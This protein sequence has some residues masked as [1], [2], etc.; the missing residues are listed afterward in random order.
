MTAI[1]TPTPVRV[2]PLAGVLAAPLWSIVSLTQAATREGFD[3]T[4]HPL[5]ALSN[6][7]PGWLQ[8][9]NFVVAGVLMFVGASALP[10]TWAPRLVRLA[11]VGMV[12]AGV[13]TM[14]AGGGFPVGTPTPTTLSWH[15]YG[16][17]AAGTLTFATL[18][19][20]CY[21]LARHL[22]GR[23]AWLARAAGTALLIGDLWA[24]SGAPAGSLTL[25]IGAIAAMACVS[26]VTARYRTGS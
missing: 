16:H 13:F 7:S 5:S 3:L 23:A 22:P 17:M 9:A 14:D 26:V 25:A 18:I 11:G 15:G 12:A 19:A 4:R 10:G 6:G 2:A 24:M 21:V 1:A 20:A 8:I